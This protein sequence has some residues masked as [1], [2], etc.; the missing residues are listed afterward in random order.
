MNI[1]LSDYVLAGYYITK[2]VMRTDYQS[3]KLL[4]EKFLK[5]LSICRCS[6]STTHWS[7]PYERQRT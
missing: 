2:Y 6:S 7:N 4:P 5:T 3:A 1:D